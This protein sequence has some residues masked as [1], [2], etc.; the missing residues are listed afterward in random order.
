LAR[1]GTAAGGR[2]AAARHRAAAEGLAGRLPALQ[3]AADRVAI[4]VMQGVH[5]RRRVGT[6]EAFWQFRR[7]E[8]G[9]PMSRI[10]WRQTA[11]RE[12][13]FVRE[14]EWEAAQSVW[15][16]R[17]NSASMRWRSSADLPEKAERA[18]LLTLALIAVLIRGG[19]RVA[20]L[21][22]SL[23]PASGRGALSRLAAGLA[24]AEQLE[25]GLPPEAPLPRHATVTLIGDFFSPLPMVDRHWRALAARGVSGLALQ[26]VDPAE[27]TLPFAG[28]TRFE[29]LEFEGEAL[30]PRVESVREDYAAAFRRHREG[31]ASIARAVG[32]R[33]MVHH[34][35][36]SAESALMA[37]WLALARGGGAGRWKSA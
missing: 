18:D 10:D 8:P 9:D 33:F 3:I 16:W 2:D 24:D 17:D 5:G 31:L 32:W 19:E 28:R 15:L 26:I 22:Q 35:D 4:T 1:E 29:G 23:R 30:I 36:R 20:L 13:V 7:Y 14:T 12:H 34:T 11:K 25:H 21:G 6:G 27:E 37:L